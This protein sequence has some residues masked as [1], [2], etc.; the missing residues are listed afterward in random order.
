MDSINQILNMNLATIISVIFLIVVGIT[1]L[2]KLKSSTGIKTKNDIEKTEINNR[3]EKLEGHDKARYEKLSEISNVLSQVQKTVSDTN[4]KMKELPIIKESVDENRKL[5][6]AYTVVTG[7]S[8]LYRLHKEFMTQEYVDESGLK[9]FIEMGKV[10][11]AAGGDDIFHN[12][13][14]PEVMSLPVK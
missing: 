12:K 10:Y 7:R 13:L 5:Q 3:V 14:Y 6:D 4:E 8:T 9:T 1:E 2:I 11:E